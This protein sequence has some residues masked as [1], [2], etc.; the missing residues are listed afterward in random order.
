MNTIKHIQYG[1]ESPA[2]TNGNYSCIMIVDL[3]INGL[4][5]IS[6]TI[7]FEAVSNNSMTGLEVDKQR[8]TAID[9]IIDKLNGL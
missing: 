3:E 1:Q 6:C 5:D 4:P 2:D 8:H 9:D 7:Q